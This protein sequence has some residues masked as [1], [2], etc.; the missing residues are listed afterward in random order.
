MTISSDL[1]DLT[2]NIHH[3]CGPNREQGQ[4]TYK[5]YQLTRPE[6][7]H[8]AI[9]GMS[10]MNILDLAVADIERPD[11]RRGDLLKKYFN[12]IKREDHKLH[13]PRTIPIQEVCNMISGHVMK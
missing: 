8:T 13:H 3:T 4:Q 9:L 6:E 7:G 2:W 11:T 12:Q 5:L 10:H 1:S